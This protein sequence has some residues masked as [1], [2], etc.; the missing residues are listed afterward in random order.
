[1]IMAGLNDLLNEGGSLNTPD[2]ADA[3]G[4]S[5]NRDLMADARA[6]LSGN[7][8]MAVLGYILYVVLIMSFSLFLIASMLFVS[9]VSSLSGS[10]PEFALHA[11][12]LFVN[13]VEMLVSGA[14]VV[15]FMGF[16]LGIAQEGEARL[17][18]LFTGFRR[19]WKSF[20]VYFL[21]SLFILLWS[22][23]LIIPGIIAAFRYAMA[24][25]IIAD[26]GDCGPLE[27]IRRSKEMM[28]GSKW[29]FFCLHWRFFGWALLA[30]IITFG[31][32]WIWL[33]P[34]IQTTFAKFYEDVK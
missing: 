16:F 4:G 15:G 31:I 3:V 26:D 18:L 23:L 13:L 21:T 20:G 6:A 32:G 8:G 2:L 22:L 19:F 10:N 11:M 14:I 17:E 9:V 27:A 33:V 1:M 24:F 28:K 12:Q 34:Y 7:W 29:K 30:S 5:S 25:F